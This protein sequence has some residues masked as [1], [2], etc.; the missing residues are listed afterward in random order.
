MPV[1]VRSSILPTLWSSRQI[2]TAHIS[3]EVLLYLHSFVNYPHVSLALH[4]FCRNMYAILQLHN[5]R[6]CKNVRG[7]FFIFF[8]SFPSRYLPLHY[9]GR[10][11]ASVHPLPINHWNPVVETFIRMAWTAKA[12]KAILFSVLAILLEDSWTNPINN[13]TFR[14]SFQ[15]TR[16]WCRE[17]QSPPSFVFRKKIECSL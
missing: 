9:I 6:R 8:V 3:V 4:G 16:C 11:Y 13:S 2:L 14:F 12:T 1:A 7:H 5:H 15:S 10:I 17:S